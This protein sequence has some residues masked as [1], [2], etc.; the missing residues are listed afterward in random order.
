LLRTIL[1]YPNK[2]LKTR[3]KDVL[4]FDDKLH[5]LLDDMYETMVNHSGVGLAGIQIGVPL[6]VLIIN[7]PEDGGEQKKEN[8][9]EMINPNFIKKDGLIKFMEG[10]L[11][12]P[13]FFEEVERFE[14]IEIEYFDRFGTKKNLVANGFLAV[15]IQHEMDHLLGYLFV[16]KLSIIKRKKFEKEY[17]KKNKK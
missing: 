10:C 5:N 7:I 15:A 2:I 14:N 6:R 11:S 9:I 1:S 4:E 3:S 17:K 12:V 16:E 13:D 8:L